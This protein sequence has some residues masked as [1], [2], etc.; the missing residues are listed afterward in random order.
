MSPNDLG[1]PEFETQ[2]I[3]K[4]YKKYF[5]SKLWITQYWGP[6]P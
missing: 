3:F 4:G 2:K 5:F 1:T 6:T